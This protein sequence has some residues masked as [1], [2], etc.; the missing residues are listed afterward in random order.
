MSKK[1]KK[2]IVIIS[3]VASVLFVLHIAVLLIVLNRQFNKPKTVFDYPYTVWGSEEPYIWFETKK[4]YAFED[5]PICGALEYDGK[6]VEFEIRFDHH[7]NVVSMYLK[8][9]S[10]LDEEI[11]IRGTLENSGDTFVFTFYEN[12]DDVWNGKYKEIVF[13]KDFKL[14]NST[15]VSETSVALKADPVS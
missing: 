2:T 3:I 6:A 7:S 8:K 5:D 4:Q 12:S 10:W 15:T 1:K 13:V 11:I 14:D 9:E